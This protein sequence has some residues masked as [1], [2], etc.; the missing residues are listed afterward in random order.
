MAQI[1]DCRYSVPPVTIPQTGNRRQVQ[2]MAGEIAYF[3][4]HI[5]K[6]NAGDCVGIISPNSTLYSTLVLGI[7]RAG[8][9]CATLNPIYSP[10]ELE[11]P[12]VDSDLKVIFTHPSI[13]GNVRKAWSMSKRSFKLP[14]GE[15]PIWLVDDADWVLTQS[16]GER[17][18]RS[19]LTSNELPV[20]SVNSEEDLAFI[21][22]SSGT[23]GKPKGVMLTHKNM[24][25]GTDTFARVRF[26]EFGPGHTALA[27]LPFFHIFG[28]NFFNLA[29]FMTGTRIVVLPRFDIDIFCAAV[30][31][32]RASMAIVVPPILLALARHP[33][34]SKYDLSTL[35]VGLC[36]AAP[37][38]PELCEEVQKR[39]PGFVISQGYGLSETAPVALRA[40]TDQHRKNLGTAGE[41]V[42]HIQIR[43]VN[44]DGVDVAHKQ[45]SEGT[46]GEIW[47]RGPAVMKGYLNN[48][49]ATKECITED[50]WFKSGDIAIIKNG[51][52]FIVDRMKELIKYKGFQV[53]PAELEDLLLSHPKIQDCAVVGVYVKEEATELPRAYVTPKP[54][55]LDLKS[56]SQTDQDRLCQEILDWFN[57]KVANHKKLRGGVVFVAEVPKSASGKILRRVLRDIANKNE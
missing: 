36:G 11:H 16:T 14:N 24:I 9:V 27:V 8:C 23:S 3:L 10:E 45:G 1:I 54:S 44:H 32:F 29:A 17:D 40:T 21:V 31:H 41:V 49:L 38:G 30:Q 18:F 52:F 28:L 39:L 12:I 51:L 55:A 33:A 26:G 13:L 25:F 34:V 42:P 19:V 5:L 6:L 43:L 37:L 53:S 15:N 57:P 47:I 22:Y 48:E 4:R 7:V 20:V 50:G 35:K 2:T 46:P 56:S